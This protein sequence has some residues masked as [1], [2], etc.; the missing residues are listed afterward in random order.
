MSRETISRNGETSRAPGRA[1][2]PGPPQING[3]PGR[4]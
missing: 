3:G 1:A 4:L 2:E